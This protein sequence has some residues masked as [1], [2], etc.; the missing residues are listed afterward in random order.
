MSGSENLDSEIDKETH[1]REDSP[2]ESKL[3]ESDPDELQGEYEEGY[4]SE[5][6]SMKGTLSKWTNYLHG[7]QERYFVLEEGLLSYFKSELDTQYGCR[8]SLSLYKTKIALH[9]FDAL[10]FDIRGH[11]S[12][13]FLRASSE[14]EKQQWVEAI[15]SSKRFIQENGPGSVT[16]I[17][18]QGSVLSLSALS[19]GS[20]GSLKLQVTHD[21]HSKLSE[22]ETYREILCRQVDLLQAYFETC[23]EGSASGHHHLSPE[24][25][26]G[27]SNSSESIDNIPEEGLPTSTTSSPIVRKNSETRPPNSSHSPL[28]SRFMPKPGGHRRTGSDPFA[29]RPSTLQVPRGSKSRPFSVGGGSPSDVAGMDIRAEAVTFKATTT[30][31]ISTLSQCIELMSK[32]EETWQKKL[33]KEQEKRVKAEAAAQAAMNGPRVKAYKYAGPDFEEGPHSAL[34]EDEF[35]DA[36]EMAYQNDEIEPTVGSTQKNPAPTTVS[37]SVPVDG[38]AETATDSFNLDSITL[39]SPSGVKHR[40]SQLVND[41][42]NQYARYIFEPVDS[43]VWS[44]VHEDGDMMVHRR[45]LEEDGVVVDPLKAVYNAQ[46]ISAQELSNFFFDK[47]TRLEWEGTLE[48]VDTVETLAEDT[49]VFHQ[50]HKRVWPSTQRESLFCSH[51]CTLVGAPRPENMIGH[52][53][54]VCN[55]SIDHDSVPASSKL[56]R[57]TIH[58]G[59]VCQTIASGKVEPGKESELTRKDITCKLHYAVNVN[60]GGWAPPSVVRAIGKREVCKFIKKL[61]ETCQKRLSSTPL[62]L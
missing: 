45:E 17:Q 58:A 8:G 9:E 60:P 6:P 51:L 13:F 22:L 57:A 23:A 55:F 53:W 12:T 30:G 10:R 4:I 29:F 7:W 40:L 41:K 32:K 20:I 1:V 18:R 34:K 21:L 37:G 49:M 27:I 5:S 14:E 39:R 26:N 19:Q 2:L 50:L 46:G 43:E 25:N 59:L 54:M 3:S 15:E 38:D 11:G 56:I 36:L 52:T 31:L 24:M 62:T 48:S 33:E 47:E 28:P 16:P 61:S 42:T 44:L 35:F